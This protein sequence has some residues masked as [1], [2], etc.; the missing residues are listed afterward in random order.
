[1]ATPRLARVACDLQKRRAAQRVRIWMCASPMEDCRRRWRAPAPRTARNARLPPQPT[2]MRKRQQLILPAT[3]KCW[4]LRCQRAQGEGCGGTTTVLRKSSCWQGSSECLPE[5]RPAYKKFWPRSAPGCPAARGHR[6]SPPRL[7]R[8]HGGEGLR[9][10]AEDRV[11]GGQGL[12]GHAHEAR[13]AA[14]AAAL[15]D[16]GQVLA[17]V[18]E[19]LDVPLPRADGLGEQAR[20]RP[21]ELDGA[22]VLVELVPGARAAHLAPGT[23]GGALEVH[24]LREDHG[25]RPAR[26]LRRGAVRHPEH[27]REGHAA[28]APLL[29]GLREV[30]GHG[31]V[32]RVAG[33]GEHGGRAAQGVGVVAVEVRGHAAARLVAQELADGREAALVAALLLALLQLVLHEPGHEA[34]RL[35]LRELQRRVALALQ[36]QLLLDEVRQA[37]EERPRPLR[38]L[39]QHLLHGAGH[40]QGLELRDEAPELGD[41][42]QQTLGHQDGAEVFALLGAHRHGVRDVLDDLAEGHALL[43]HLLREQQQVGLRLQRGLQ[44]QVG[45]GQLAGNAGPVHELQ[46]VVVLAGAGAVD[47]RVAH[48]VRHGLGSGVEAQGGLHELVHHAAL[49]AAGHAHDRRLHLLL[50]EVLRDVRGVRVR[51]RASDEDQPS[52]VQLRAGV[53]G[54]L[55]LL[56]GLDAVHGA[57]QELQAARALVGLAELRR[58]LH[59]VLAVEAL[60]AAHEAQDLAPGGRLQHLHEAAEE[61]VAAGCLAAAEDDAHLLARRRRLLGVRGRELQQGRVHAREAL[62]DDVRLVLVEADRG[63]AL[64]HLHRGEV[65]LRKGGRPPALAL[66][67]PLL[68]AGARAPR[69]RREEEAAHRLRGGARRERRQRLPELQLQRQGDVL[70]RLAALHVELRRARNAVGVCQL[71]LAPDLAVGHVGLRQL[72]VELDERLL[73]DGLVL[74][75]AALD[76]AEGGDGHAAALP[77]AHGRQQV[78][79][80]GDE[81]RALVA[82]EVGRGGAQGVAVGGVEDRGR[83]GAALVAVGVEL[84]PEAAAVGALGPPRLELHG[85]GGRQQLLRLDLGHLDVAVGVPVQQQLRA[86]EVR[87]VAEGGG[88]LGR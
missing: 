70:G 42:R 50:L 65:E 30:G 25:P 59:A 83:A 82:E 57:A 39:R 81:A 71:Q 27:G 16:G 79:H 2:S 72:P 40:G 48:E 74:A 31:H 43:V 38:Q 80:R 20:A 21:R 62:P 52:E 29:H 68:Q 18:V 64:P 3:A 49:D 11:E 5:P 86:D 8:R 58:E 12:R 85:Y 66:H 47:G 75:L 56:L 87:Q 88:V 26:L 60:G 55:Q 22:R 78:L 28:H 10:L 37:L 53:P 35:Q 69:L 24:A 67:A 14:R 23:E 4:G 63:A 32:A 34:L 44:G 76:D 7:L 84:R 46:E 19:L 17:Q 77:L 45:R 54:E 51:P 61:V 13:V 6:G 73:D 36:Q 9:D 33:G 1:M 41:G 15:G